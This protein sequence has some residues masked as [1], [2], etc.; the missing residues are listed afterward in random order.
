MPIWSKGV[1]GVIARY[2]PRTGTGYGPMQ[3]AH[4]QHFSGQCAAGPPSAA[5]LC[6]EPYTPSTNLSRISVQR[7]VPSRGPNSL[8]LL[9]FKGRQNSTDLEFF[10]VFLP[11]LSMPGSTYFAVEWYECTASVVECCAYGIKGFNDHL[12]PSAPVQINDILG[13]S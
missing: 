6:S 7:G 10:M 5:M 3:A 13:D 8:P 11:E 1:D 2:I 12:F 4:P 9:T